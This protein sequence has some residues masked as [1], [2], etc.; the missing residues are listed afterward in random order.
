[1][2]PEDKPDGAPGDAPGD[3]P[4]GHDG[5]LAVAEE[6]RKQTRCRSPQAACLDVVSISSCRCQIS[7]TC[8]Q[9]SCVATTEF[10][11]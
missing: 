1:M 2:E 3:A 10:L 8:S 4:D 11:C 6:I 5:T 7:R 9:I